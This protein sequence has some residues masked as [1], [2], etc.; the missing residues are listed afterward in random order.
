VVVVMAAKKRPSSSERNQQPAT[1]GRGE[2][3]ARHEQSLRARRAADQAVLRAALIEGEDER[4][5]E[6]VWLEEFSFPAEPDLVPTARRRVAG[7]VGHCGLN[8]TSLFD[9]VLAVDEALTNAVQHGSP[10]GG[11]SAVGVRVGL[12]GRCVAVEVRDQGGG[13]PLCAAVLP[14]SLDIRGRGIPFMRS[15][16]DEVSFEC[17]PKGTFVLLV[18]RA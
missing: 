13:F 15:L 2:L 17:T 10:A 7:V 5:H 6:L 16:V 8:G 12:V 9:L 3:R 18:K 14:D 1:P 11:D 4:T